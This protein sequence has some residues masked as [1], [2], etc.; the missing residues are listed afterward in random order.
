MNDECQVM[1]TIDIFLCYGVF[2]RTFIFLDPS[3]LILRFM[4]D[5]RLFM[6][7]GIISEGRRDRGNKEG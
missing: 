1:G 2:E 6:C 3:L 4:E 5:K 7:T